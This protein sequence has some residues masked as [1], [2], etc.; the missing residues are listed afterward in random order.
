M[1]LSAHILL[2][3]DGVSDPLRVTRLVGEERIHAPF[4]LELAVLA[5]PHGEAL[6]SL[7]PEQIL[8]APAVITFQDDPSRELRGIVNELHAEGEGYRIA[9]VP[10][11]AELVD[12]IDYRV[13]LDQDAVTIAKALL[14]ERGIEV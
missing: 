10:P 9:V 2:D 12:V 14:S 1:S 4:R 3:I 13:F 6:L 11:V 5:R 7:D 8:G